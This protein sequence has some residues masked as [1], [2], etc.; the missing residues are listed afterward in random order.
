MIIEILG[1][2]SLGVRGMS[3]FISTGNHKILIDPGIALGYKG[4][5]LLPHPF[6][7]GVGEMIRSKILARLKEA[8]DIVISHFHGDHVPLK[9][10]NPYQLS[11]DS[12]RVKKDV[13]F[14]SK[15]REF[16]TPDKARRYD[17]LAAVFNL[18]DSPGSHYGPMTFSDPLP[19]G[20]PG[21][22]EKTVMMTRVE[23]N[24]FVF[25]H[26]SDIQLL[27]REAIEVILD[28]APDI[29]LADGPPLYLS[30]VTKENIEE[31][32]E[33]ALLLS[34]NIGTVILDHHLLRDCRGLKWLE[35]LSAESKNKVVCAADFM[36]Q[37]KM[38]LEAGRKKLYRDMPVS[39][40]WHRKYVL[41]KTNTEK[42]IKMGRELYGTTKLQ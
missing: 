4:D 36:K 18:I 14:R 29:L 1:A 22:I 17:D 25:V 21:S 26:A 39:E 34:E 19:H 24:G 8:T 42:Y 32:W 27:N 13:V 7:V 33:N 15:S 31:A 35:D 23:E 16:L 11:L 28:W 40:D 9:D 41:G 38:L 10:A 2:E 12:V 5:G 20:K 3:T 37:D 30:E 6:Q